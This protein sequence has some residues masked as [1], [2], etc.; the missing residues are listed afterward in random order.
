[1]LEYVDSFAQQYRSRG[2][3]LDTSPLL[4]LYLGLHDP[5]QI[6]RFSRTRK[7]GFT[8]RDYEFLLAFVSRFDRL[9][10]TPHILTEVSNFLGQLHGRVKNECFEVFARQLAEST[11][12]EH[13][14]LAST[15][16][17]KPEFVPFGITDASI[18]EVATDTYLVL[19]TDARLNAYLVR[20]GIASLN[21]N[22]FRLS[23]SE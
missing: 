20:Q 16:A 11:T 17:G 19:T 9:V 23:L 7:E 21:Y 22:N 14:P 8:R 5:D 6:E 3:L 13:L 4:L 2:L 10:T 12:H 1:M 15:L 18:A